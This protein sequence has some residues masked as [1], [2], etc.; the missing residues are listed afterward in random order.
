MCWFWF[1]FQE[2]L[3]NGAA[4]LK[5]RI[6]T[7]SYGGQVMWAYFCLCILVCF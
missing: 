5:A 2:A 4:A 7:L 6:E 3:K 1:F